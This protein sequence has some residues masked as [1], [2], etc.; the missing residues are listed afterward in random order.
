MLE[1]GVAAS[2]ALTVVVEC[3]DL[4]RGVP[5]VDGR[6]WTPW[7]ISAKTILFLNSVLDL[8]HG[9]WDLD[10]YRHQNDANPQH[11]SRQSRNS[12]GNGRVWKQK[13]TAG[14]AREPCMGDRG[15]Q[16]NILVTCIILYSVIIPGNKIFQY[17]PVVY[18]VPFFFLRFPSGFQTTAKET[19]TWRKS[20]GLRSHHTNISIT[21]I[22]KCLQSLQWY[23]QIFTVIELSDYFWLREDEIFLPISALSMGSPSGPKTIPCGGQGWCKNSNSWRRKYPLYRAGGFPLRD[24]CLSPPP[25]SYYFL[26]SH[27]GRKYLPVFDGKLRPVLL[28]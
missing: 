8:S 26:P 28:L 6:T 16:R 24:L 2:C 14:G 19:K 10:P 3:L 21:F 9:K 4:V 5:G 27:H 23:D 25:P 20:H 15:A 7:Q 1:G 13:T 22:S 11:C 12:E 18:D 17:S